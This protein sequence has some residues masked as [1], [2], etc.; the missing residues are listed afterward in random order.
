MSRR[1]FFRSGPRVFALLA[2]TLGG[3][4]NGFAASPQTLSAFEEKLV[5]RARDRAG[6][7]LEDPECQKILADF[8]DAEG[9]TLRENL[10]ARFGVPPAEYL[11]MIPFLDGSPQRLCRWSKVDLV[12]TPGVARIF[13]CGQFARTETSDPWTAEAIVIHEMLHTLGLGENP[14]TS[15]EITKRVKGRCR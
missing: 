11:R 7:S 5:A 4:P 8:K 10:D 14:P 2:A 13:V 9:R 1:R 6:R 3:T 12:T 15:T